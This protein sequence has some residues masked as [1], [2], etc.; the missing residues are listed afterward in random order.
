MSESLSITVV[1]AGPFAESVATQVRR[2]GTYRLVGLQ[3]EDDAI[4]PGADVLI[5]LVAPDKRTTVAERGLSAGVAVATLP[6]MTNGA[7]ERDLAASGRLAQ[8]SELI[9]YAALETLLGQVREGVL[10][11]RY[12]LF[13]AHRVRQG[14][15]DVFETIGASLLCYA[16]DL[17]GG[18]PTTEQ[19]TRGQLFGDVPDSWLLMLRQPDGLV[20]TVEFAAS[21]P[22]SAAADEQI[23]VEANGSDAVLRAEPTRQAV[24]VAAKGGSTDERGW[25]RDEAVGFTPAAIAAAQQPDPARE[26]A[27]LQ[28]LD[29][30][31]R[32]ADSGQPVALN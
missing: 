22:R 4:E 15:S 11:R 14:A 7:T 20:A 1:G 21:L 9:G 25:W 29:A 24:L 13:A 19:A 2:S 31:R 18:A 27:A 30:V 17:L 28:L 16:L 8:V 23:L 6:L 12:S 3:A 32:A 26:A 5:S 10:G